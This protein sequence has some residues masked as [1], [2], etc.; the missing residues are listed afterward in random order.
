MGASREAVLALEVT[1][2]TRDNTGILPPAQYLQIPYLWFHLSMVLTLSPSC[3]ILSMLF[4]RY[5]SSFHFG[6]GG[7]QGPQ[8]Y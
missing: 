1:V 7:Q 3:L 2:I 6:T 4:K 5:F 8:R